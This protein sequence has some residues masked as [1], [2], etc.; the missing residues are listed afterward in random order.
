MAATTPVSAKHLSGPAMSV[1]YKALLENQSDYSQARD[2]TPSQIRVM[3]A[4]LSPIS[5]HGS[6]C[7][8]L[9][10]S[11]NTLLFHLKNIFSKLG[12]DS[13]KKAVWRFVLIYREYLSQLM[14]FYVLPED[15]HT[16][17]VAA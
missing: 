9:S 11:M 10:I 5:D 2:L 8:E 16:Q 17:L 4:F 14:L 15:T 13:L 1:V 7:G 3:Q 6:V 12:V